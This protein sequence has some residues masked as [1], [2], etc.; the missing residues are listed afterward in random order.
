MAPNENQSKFKGK[1]GQPTNVVA[2]Y[3]RMGYKNGMQLHQY[4][5]DYYVLREE[6]DRKEISTKRRFNLLFVWKF[7]YI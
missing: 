1:L 2:N 7:D 6:K 5:V 3:F 4:R